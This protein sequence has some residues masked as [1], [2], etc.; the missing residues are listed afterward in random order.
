MSWRGTTR[1]SD[2]IQQTRIP[3]S[4]LEIQ[5][6][7]VKRSIVVKASAE[8]AFSVFTN[9]IGRWWPPSHSIG[10]TPP[11][12]VIVEPRAGG[13]C[14]EVGTDGG[15]CEWG[16]ILLWEPPQRLVLGWQINANWKYDPTFLTEVEVTFTPVT[17]LETRVDLEHRNLERY[18]DQAGRIRDAIGS[19]SGWLG[20]LK[21]F[22]SYAQ[23]GDP[24][25][26]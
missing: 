5:P 23:L 2:G 7:P 12:N 26:T 9:N 3:L 19:D 13:R 6:A 16:K 11:T 18:G 21:S 8:R 14:Y 4:K 15:E 10:A 24:A 1:K 22:V 20:I 25:T 17:N